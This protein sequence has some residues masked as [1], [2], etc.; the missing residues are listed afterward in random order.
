MGR[1]ELITCR[2]AAMLMWKTLDSSNSE[3]DQRFHKSIHKSILY[4]ICQ[5]RGQRNKHPES[6]RTNIP[7]QEIGIA[8]P[9][10][11]PVDAARL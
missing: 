10:V 2:Q 6:G 5:K 7:Q 8:A 9:P 11:S 1:V 4:P 3:E